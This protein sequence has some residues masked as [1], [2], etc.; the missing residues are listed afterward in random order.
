MTPNHVSQAHYS[1]ESEGQAE[2][3]V[4]GG[5]N[6]SRGRYD[7][8][9]GRGENN[10]IQW[11]V[12]SR[13][14]EMSITVFVQTIAASL[15]LQFSGDRSFIL[16]SVVLCNLADYICCMSAIGLR[17]RRPRIARILERIGSLTAAFGFILMIAMFLSDYH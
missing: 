8:E 13:L 16:I 2:D 12:F 7:L 17:S 5:G 9:G 1:A 15:A 10:P 6:E 14:T 11:A 4:I 3:E